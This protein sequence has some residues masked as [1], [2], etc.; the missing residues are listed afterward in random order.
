MQKNLKRKIQQIFRV[1]DS[2]L[3]LIRK[4]MAAAK[5]QNKEMYY[6][7]MVLG[8]YVVRVDFSAVREMVKLLRNATNNL[9]QIAKRVNSDGSIFANDIADIQADYE[10]LWCQAEIIFRKIAETEF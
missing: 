2:E 9:N 3:E 10:K 5:I 4:K 6:R 7:K 8:G 1:D